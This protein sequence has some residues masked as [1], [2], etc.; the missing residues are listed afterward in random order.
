MMKCVLGP[1][2]ARPY[3]ANSISRASRLWN[4]Q[5]EALGAG[6]LQR[7]L[8]D[9]LSRP[10]NAE[11]RRIIATKLTTVAQVL[12]LVPN[13]AAAVDAEGAQE[14]GG[15]AAATG[16]VVINTH[17][18]FHPGA[19]HIRMLLLSA[20]LNEAKVARDAWE[21][22]TGV[23]LALVFA[24]D[25]NS[26]PDTGAV[27][28]VASGRVSAQHPE[29]VAAAGFAWGDTEGEE[30]EE[31]LGSGDMEG[32][33]GGE[34]TGGSEA[35]SLTGK[36]G[37]VG[38]GEEQRRR[39]A[40][41]E[42][43]ARGVDLRHDLVLASSDELT[44]SFT[45]YVRGYIGCLDYI[46]Y[47][48]TR[49]RV[50]QVVPLPPEDQ[51]A[52]TALPSRRFPS[53]HLSLCCDLEFTLLQGED[54]PGRGAASGGGDRQAQQVSSRY[55][56]RMSERQRPVQPASPHLVYKGAAALQAGDVVAVPTDTVYGL[57]AAAG[58]TEGVRRLFQIKGRSASKAI[59]VCLSEVADVYKYGDASGLPDGLLEALLP[60][61]ITL[62]LK[63][64]P[65][66]PVCD[67][68]TAGLGTLALRV[69]GPDVNAMWKRPS[70]EGRSFCRALAAASG[71]LALTS[72]NPSN[73]SSSV[74]TQ[75]F[76]PLWPQLAYVFDGGVVG[77]DRQGSTIIDLTR[78]SS[79]GIFVI[80]R[81]GAGL[82]EVLRVLQR[83][84]LA[85]APA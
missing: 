22:E 44:T 4:L 82:P 61:P 49:L 53:D 68:V 3:G 71:A 32:G 13:R 54:C 39:S 37:G 83:F 9:F 12:C 35:A 80:T 40:M 10:C 38:E 34:G 42:R 31:D 62:I 36:Q 24:G 73:S 19:S 74:C 76:R 65:D 18:F 29:W 51:V 45:N 50:R 33:G 78:A 69:P 41:A 47:E 57:A 84:D 64:L 2:N 55:P 8:D 72:A 60:G 25:F 27:E 56:A 66:A 46:F 16:L 58:N 67:E 28:F 81:Q 79:D 48:A 75:E 20:I 5:T 52:P 70:G 14:E 26:E 59:A 21:R 1:L 7:E 11:L 77:Q 63:R 6:G 15:E 85:Q 30:A 17:L 23:R 43:D